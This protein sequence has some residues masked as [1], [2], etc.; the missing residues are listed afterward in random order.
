MDFFFSLT[1]NFKTQHS[2]FSWKRLYLSKGGRVTLIKSSLSNLPTYLL[3]LFPIPY[4]LQFLWGGIGE[5]FKFHL[6]N[7]S[8]VCSPISNGGLGIRN[9]R[10]FNKALLGKWL[11]RYAHERKAWWKSVVDAKYGSTWA[12]WCS[13]DP[14]WVT[15]S[16]ALEE[17]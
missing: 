8:K 4:S 17:Y 12:G 11:W 3:S 9:L 13:V 10:I 15:R 6:V 7:W 16:G 5:E 2:K 1:Y 14:P